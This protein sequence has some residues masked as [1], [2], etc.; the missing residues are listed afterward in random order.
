M[1]VFRGDVALYVPKDAVET[2]KKAFDWRIFKNI[3]EFDAT[4][5]TGTEADKNRENNYYDLSGLRLSA[6]KKGLNIINGRK[7]MVK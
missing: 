1:T 5:I 7:V 4:G 6:P 3:M 2:Y